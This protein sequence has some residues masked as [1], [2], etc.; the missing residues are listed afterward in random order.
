VHNGVLTRNGHPYAAVGFDYYDAFNRYLMNNNTSYRAGFAALQASGVQFIRFQVLPYWPVD[1][2]PYMSHSQLLFTKL[3]QFVAD[4]AS[5][6]IC[7]VPSVFWNWSTPPDVEGE[8]V[9]AW[10]N[11]NSKTSLFAASFVK[12]LASRYAGNPTIWMWEMTNEINDWADLP[13]AYQYGEWGTNTSEGQPATRGPADDYTSAQMGTAYSDFVNA[14]HAGDLN[15]LVEP[16]YDLPRNNAYNLKAFGS[17]STDTVAQFDM[18]VSSQYSPG[19]VV[20]MHVYPEDFT[21]PKALRFADV[22][23]DAEQYLP[24]AQQAAADIHEPLF[25]GEYG[26]PDNGVSPYQ[27]TALSDTE[28]QNLTNTLVTTLTT[29]GKCN[30]L[31]AA[32]VFD[33]PFQDTQAQGNFDITW[34][35]VTDPPPDHVNRL[36]MVSQ[37]NQTLSKDGCQN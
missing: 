18:A 33:F 29:G 6:N 7:L 13:N 34:A 27:T 30:G 24:Y 26:V 20:S 1:A 32:W 16:G 5:Y 11:P 14:V 36:A 12:Q 22:S 37:A 8:P 23:V 21:D 25:I 2:S 35:G 10:A 3:D 28:F 15:V 4:A 19:N 31:A 17:Y 9:S